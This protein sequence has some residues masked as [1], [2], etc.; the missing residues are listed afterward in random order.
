MSDLDPLP[1][2][3]ECA[4]EVAEILSTCEYLES[5]FRR[6]LA[7]MLREK[8][9]IVFEEVPIT[10]SFEDTRIPFGYGFCDIVVA[11]KDTGSILIELKITSKDA[12]G[13]LFRYMRHWNYTNLLLGMTINFYNDQA[14]IQEYEVRGSTKKEAELKKSRT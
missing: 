7:R 3:R 14:K 13:Q 10:Y 1:I 2:I 5:N 12:S 11:D 9:L 6:I 8:G 4:N